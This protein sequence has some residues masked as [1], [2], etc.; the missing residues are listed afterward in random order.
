M[1]R[2]SKRWQRNSQL[3]ERRAVEL[4][5]ARGCKFV[6]CGHTHLALSA[7]DQGIHYFNTGTWTEHPPCPF[8]AVRGSEVSL[9][10]WPLGGPGEREEAAGES[11][12]LG[13]G[14]PEPLAAPA[15]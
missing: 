7:V 14:Y 9:Q 13:Q 12:P 11:L 10:F 8:L 1:R 4:A 2:I 6:T 5:R 3:V 15:R